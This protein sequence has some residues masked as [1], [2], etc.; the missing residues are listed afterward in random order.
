MGE[1]PLRFLA[2]RRPQVFG[3]VPIVFFSD[4]IVQRP[5]NSTGIIAEAN[6]ADTV[7]L[8]TALQPGARDMYVISGAST[9]DERLLELAKTQFRSFEPTLT[10][11]YL[12]GLRTPELQQRLQ[13]LSPNSIVYYLLVDRDGSG[14]N[15]H[16]LEYIDRI[17]AASAAPVYSWVDSLV[18]RGVVGGSLSR[19]NGGHPRPR[20]HRDSGP[21]RGT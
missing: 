8:A 7:T 15:V 4:R 21:R 12:S 3:D 9:N 14:V 13:A 19:R 1:L 20:D 5:S 2:A 6:F 16:P 17:T 11:H 18:D 10:V